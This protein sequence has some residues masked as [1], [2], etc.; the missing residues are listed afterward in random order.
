MYL[1]F[2]TAF[3][4]QKNFGKEAR[5]AAWAA[6]QRTLHGLQ[7]TEAK[8]PFGRNTYGETSVMAEEAKRRAEIARLVF[9]QYSSPI[10]GNM[11]SNPLL[12]STLAL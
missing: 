8:V 6:E 3:S 12:L 1:I 7:S 4:N 2:Q 10:E 5:E 11:S 9:L